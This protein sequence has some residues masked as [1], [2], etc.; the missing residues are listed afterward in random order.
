MSLPVYNE[1]RHPGEFI[2]TEGRGH[3]SREAVLIGTGQ[4]IIPGTILGKIAVP[5]DETVSILTGTNQTSGAANTGNGVP[6]LASPATSNAAI[7]GDY[8][9]IATAPNVFS[10]QTPQGKEIGPLTPGVAFNKE[11]RLT[12]PAGSTAFAPGD[13][14]IVR[15]GVQNVVDFSYVAL[16][17]AAADGSQNAA[18]IAIYP[19]TTDAATQTPIAAIVRHAEVM[20]PMLTWPAGI[21]AAQ[22][23]EAT[24]QLNAS[25]III[26]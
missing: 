3:F 11:I 12:I 7:D 13:S 2:L 10:V 25:G 14:F 17:P 4:T 5:A 6:A 19:V 23:A 16:N 26:R 1:P 21:T 18:G 9:L 22:Q 15:V 24:N 20:G 8:L